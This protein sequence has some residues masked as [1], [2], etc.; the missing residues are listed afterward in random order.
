[1]A[2]HI[3]TEYYWLVFPALCQ[4]IQRR[5]L[6]YWSRKLL[7]ILREGLKHMVVLSGRLAWLPAG[8]QPC[9]WLDVIVLNAPVPSLPLES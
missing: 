2:C 4:N 5:I 8:C 9:F 3:I 6:K 1:V 7:D